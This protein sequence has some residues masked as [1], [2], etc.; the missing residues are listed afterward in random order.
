MTSAR[1]SKRLVAEAARLLY[2]G[3]PNP[4]PGSEI[5]RRWFQVERPW[6]RQSAEVDKAVCA[7]TGRVA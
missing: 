7:N 6:A 4:R 2:R 3:L 1:T 5:R